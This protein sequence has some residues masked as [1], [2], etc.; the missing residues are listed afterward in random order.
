MNVDPY[1]GA[2]ST[3]QSHRNDPSWLAELATAI[4]EH[5]LDER[6]ADVVVLA[7]QLHCE[8]N[9]QLVL[10]IVRDRTQPTIARERAFGVMHGIALAGRTSHRSVAA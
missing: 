4:A 7:N 10:D 8:G 2:M 5:G 6:E 3:N 9:R 1:G